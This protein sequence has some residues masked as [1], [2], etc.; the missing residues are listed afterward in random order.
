VRTHPFGVAGG[1]AIGQAYT[2]GALVATGALLYCAASKDGDEGC[3]MRP[4]PGAFRELFIPLAG[5]W[6]ALRRDD[7]REK[8][9]YALL[10]GG[11]GAIQAAGV[12]LI[13]YDLAVPRYRVERIARLRVE[14]VADATTQLLVMKGSF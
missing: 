1:G 6:L 12:L 10:F 9:G 14:A 8:T 5:P 11:L 13:A 2:L 4:T 7:V 3:G